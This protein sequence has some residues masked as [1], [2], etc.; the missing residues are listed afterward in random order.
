MG[1]E[2]KATAV[3][4]IV[5]HTA[6]DLARA[7]YVGDSITDVQALQ[8]VARGG[9]LAVAFNG[10]RYAVANAEIAVLS[11]TAL[12]TALLVDVFAQR[13]KQAVLDLAE[14]WSR[15]AVEATSAPSDLVAALLDPS[16]TSFPAVYIVDEENV[17]T[18]TEESRH[19]RQRVRGD[20]IGRLG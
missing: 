18:V 15:R 4:T 6:G 10:N 19:V 5:S 1:G 12:V 3:R 17:E 14:H 16:S 9:G 2:G 11:D 13:G 7:M 20:A 8:L